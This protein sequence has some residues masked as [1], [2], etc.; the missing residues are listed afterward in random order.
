MALR[1]LK[2]LTAVAQRIAEDKRAPRAKKRNKAIRPDIAA[3]RCASQHVFVLEG[4][5]Y[6]CS[7]CSQLLSRSQLRSGE[8]DWCIPVDAYFVD[9]QGRPGPPPPNCFA[10]QELCRRLHF[11]D[12]HQLSR[13][14]GGVVCWKCSC[15]SA[16]S[17]SSRP[18][19]ATASQRAPP[20]TH[21]RAM[22]KNAR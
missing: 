21:D 18:T 14:P 20:I 9:P 8:L 1:V 11:D 13:F 7:T 6:R 4:R 16:S 15:W 3:L 5:C 17:R 19:S 2:R 12:S 10:S 22:K